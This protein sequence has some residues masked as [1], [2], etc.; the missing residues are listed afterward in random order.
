MR[1]DREKLE[2]PQTAFDD[3]STGNMK[4]FQ[5]KLELPQ[6]EVDECAVHRVFF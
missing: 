5:E 6:T 3:N 1:P 4:D 2:L